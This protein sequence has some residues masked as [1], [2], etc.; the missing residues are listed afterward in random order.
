MKRT[1]K[2]LLL[3][4]SVMMVVGFAGCVKNGKSDITGGEI[5]APVIANVSLQDGKCSH[6]I[7]TACVSIKT[8]AL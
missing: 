3:L 6:T 8:K 1:W 5:L 2:F 7:A 4:L